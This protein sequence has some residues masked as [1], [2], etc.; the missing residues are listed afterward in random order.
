MLQTLKLLISASSFSTAVMKGVDGIPLP[1]CG[2]LPAH[3]WIYVTVLITL[4]GVHKGDKAISYG[5]GS[6]GETKTSTEEKG[7]CE[8]L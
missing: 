2:A 1:T 6:I 7:R 4:L 3:V 5:F 8:T